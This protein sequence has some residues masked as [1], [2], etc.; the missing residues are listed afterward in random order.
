MAVLKLEDDR[1]HSLILLS[2]P[3]PTQRRR[4]AALE[5]VIGVLGKSSH[6]LAV[7]LDQRELQC[8]PEKTRS[9]RVRSLLGD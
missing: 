9:T 6:A 7:V 4:N 5:E 2:T 1:I 8:N 3:I